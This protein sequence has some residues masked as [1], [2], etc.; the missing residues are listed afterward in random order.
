MPEA[1]SA[2]VN[3]TP[4]LIKGKINSQPLSFPYFSGVF[5]SYFSKQFGED[6]RT[7]K[8]NTQK[9][10]HVAAFGVKTK[11]TAPFY[12]S[13]F[14]VFFF[15]F[16]PKTVWSRFPNFRRTCSSWR[17]RWRRPA[18]WRKWYLMDSRS[19]TWDLLRFFSFTRFWEPCYMQPHAALTPSATW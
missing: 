14:G 19:P 15:F 8:A 16:F 3:K 12:P 11:F 5:V 7:A 13:L 9:T 1:G 10:P 6:S 4:I 2:I 18:W 17:R